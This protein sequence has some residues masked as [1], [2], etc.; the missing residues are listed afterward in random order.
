[1]PFHCEPGQQLQVDF[2]KARF[3]Y[4]GH[5][6]PSTVYLFEAV[7]PWSR[8][9]YVRVCPDMKQTSWF[10]AIVDCLDKYGVPREIL[11][12]NDKSLVIKHP[13]KNQPVFHPMFEWL[14]RPL[15]SQPKACRPL[16]PQTKGRVERFGRYLQESGL[17]ECQHRGA[18]NP[19]ELQKYLDEW[20]IEVADK[21][22]V[23]EPE[24]LCYG[25]TRGELYEYE[26]QFL[27]QSPGLAGWFDF[28]PEVRRVRRDG[29]L[30]LHGVEIRLPRS[31]AN[32]TV[33]VS[34]KVN[35]SYV[36]VASVTGEVLQEGSIDPDN[37]IKYSHAQAAPAPKERTVE[38]VR[39]GPDTFDEYSRL[40]DY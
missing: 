39:S 18:K 2:V 35:G 19:V 36:I 21:R 34:V 17:P 31:M 5:P 28:L 26:K 38:D 15:N 1:M 25:K 10:M 30:S 32:G 3:Q 4:A 9:S 29:T 40:I 12:D 6:A 7:Y 24:L 23:D 33:V 13:E 8:K 11:S 14:L 22:T 37:L 20:L 16:R 27:Q